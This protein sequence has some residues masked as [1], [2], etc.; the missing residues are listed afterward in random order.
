M[1]EFC[2]C[3]AQLPPDALFCHKCGKPQRELPQPEIV[4]PPPEVPAA[5]PE[6]RPLNFHNP[7]ALRAALVAALSATLLFFLPD[8]NWM[9]AGFF[10][11]MLYRRRTGDPL[12]ME[13]GVYMGWITGVLMFGMTAVLLTVLLV[14]FRASGGITAFQSQFSNVVLDP[15]FVEALKQLQ[16]NTQVFWLMVQLFILSTLLSM[17]GGALGA[18]LLRRS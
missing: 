13:S 11:V 16:S 15:K 1:P 2:T 4:P 8:I 9:A 3:G 5:K 10:A 12:N 18:K 7:I 14:V 17:A 6:P